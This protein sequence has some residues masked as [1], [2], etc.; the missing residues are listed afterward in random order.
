VLLQADDAAGLQ[1]GEEVTLMS[2]G[3]VIISEVVKDVEGN[4]T[5]VHARLHLAGSV[6][7]TKKKFTWLAQTPE[8]TDLTLVDFDF[9]LNKDKVDEDDNI[10]DLLTPVTRFDFAAKGEPSLRQ[11]KKGE[12]IQ[13]E[14]RGFYICE[15]PYIRASD[16][17]VLYFVPDGKNMFGVKRG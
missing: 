16:P 12:I 14:R 7:S 17:I 3:N 5:S 2:W 9:L 1:V 13:V 11:L 6:K 15:R 4:V 8:L 10:E